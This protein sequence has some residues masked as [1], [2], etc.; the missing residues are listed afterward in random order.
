MLGCKISK[1]QGFVLV[2][3]F[4]GQLLCVSAC[5]NYANQ[6]TATISTYNE[7][8]DAID[9]DVYNITISGV[10]SVDD[11]IGLTEKNINFFGLDDNA[12]LRATTTRIFNI[13]RSDISITRLELSG[14]TSS[15]NGGCSLT[16]DSHL[17]I[18]DVLFSQCQGMNG[19]ALYVSNS[20][21]M[22]KNTQFIS[23][24]ASELGGAY[25]STLSVVDDVIDN[26]YAAY[27]YASVG[28]GFVF[29]SSTASMTNSHLQYNTAGTSGGCIYS[30]SS[31]V[32]MRNTILSSCA[33]GATSVGRSFGTDGGCI[34]AVSISQI[35][36]LDSTLTNCS[37]MEGG[38]IHI[39]TGL[40]KATNTVFDNSTAVSASMYVGFGSQFTCSN[41]T[42]SRNQVKFVSSVMSC[43]SGSRCNWDSSEIHHNIAS[44]SGTIYIESQSIGDFTNCQFHHN[45]AGNH[46][47][48]VYLNYLSDAHFVLCDFY[49]NSAVQNGGAI[50]LEGR[51]NSTIR[52]SNFDSNEAGSGGALSTDFYAVVSIIS[53][54]FTGNK[55]YESGGAI[56]LDG[57]SAVEI[58]ESDFILGQAVYGAGIYA[59]SSKVTLQG[60]NAVDNAATYAGGFLSGYNN[61]VIELNN[62]TL[63]G[64]SA[65]Y[66]GAV[67]SQLFSNITLANVTLEENLGIQMRKVVF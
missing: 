27:N 66:G 52:E 65:T 34:H 26:I 3:L 22:L 39:S 32:Q 2:V 25:F 45:T 37:A 46:G 19:G 13:L 41:C 6:D 21:V 16:V 18:N 33:A 35:S 47:G 10:I 12:A 59:G 4:L 42:V 30:T 38:L 43:V 51:S 40:F 49:D 60:I 31:I 20:S 55:A 28:A 24:S 29:S 58:L 36:L 62:S 15:A 9:C 14:G 67:F 61:A 44:Y 50:Y 56:H 8:I 48:V 57:F 54:V 1:Y 23:N 63:H 11:E 5:T 17:V 7:L 64:N 53:C